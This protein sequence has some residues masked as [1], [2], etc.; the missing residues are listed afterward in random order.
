M[1][2]HRTK[3]QFQNSA[4]FAEDSHKQNAP[5]YG[6]PAVPRLQPRAD[7]LP[8]EAY[9]KSLF[10]QSKPL[11]SGIVQGVTEE[12]SLIKEEES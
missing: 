12:L 11:N 4:T 8:F 6:T 10:A 7:D 5:N 3:F 9:K 2:A 1:N